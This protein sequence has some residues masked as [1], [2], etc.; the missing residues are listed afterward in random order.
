MLS[1]TP[2]KTFAGVRPLTDASGFFFR[3]HDRL[4][5]VSN[6]HVFEDKASDHF[7]DRL[8]ILV[9]TDPRDLTRSAWCRLPLYENG[10]AHWRHARDT[11]GEVDVAV[12][13]IAP[14]VLP[15]AA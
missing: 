1:V 15:E 11:G 9:H 10:L 5:L 2:V 3:A 8:E 14:G 12:L 13:E 6:R 7:P 4:F